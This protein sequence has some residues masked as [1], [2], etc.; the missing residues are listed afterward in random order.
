MANGTTSAS[1]SRSALALRI[2]AAVLGGYAFCWGFIAFAMAS[3]FGLGM[4]FHDA[5][6]LAAMLAFLIY[7][8]VFCWA[9]VARSLVR[10][11]L[12]LAGGGALMAV[13]ASLLQHRLVS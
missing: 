13:A 2:G 6:H 4:K 1:A 9:F 8:G 5:E 12:V 10:A 3:L 7:L 11:W